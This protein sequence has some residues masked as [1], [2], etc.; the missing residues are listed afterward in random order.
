M[1]NIPNYL[2]GKL[3]ETDGIVNLHGIIIR[4]KK[5]NHP[6]HLV[7]MCRQVKWNNFKRL[8]TNRGGNDD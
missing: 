6:G 2:P 5:Y 7:I 4:L 1:N 8:Y 3:T